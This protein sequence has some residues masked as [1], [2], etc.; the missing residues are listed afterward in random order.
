MVGQS[1]HSPF[2]QDLLRDVCRWLVGLLVNEPEDC[3]DGLPDGLF[4]LP[5]GERFGARV[6][7]GD[8]AFGV[9]RNHSVADARKRHTQPL[10]LLAYGLFLF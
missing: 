9:A 1:N 10:A 2:A 3:R 8:P 5:A 6:D 7:E 4:R